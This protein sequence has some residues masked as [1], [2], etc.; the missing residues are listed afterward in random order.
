MDRKRKIRKNDE[1]VGFLGCEFSNFYKCQFTINGVTFNCVEQAFMYC[2]AKLFGDHE[3]A[4]EILKSV[5]PTQCKKLGRKVKGFNDK[6]WANKREVYMEKLLFA[7]FNSNPQ[8]KKMLLDTGDRIIVECAPFDKIWGIGK[9]VDAFFES[10]CK[11]IN[12]NNNKLGNALMKVRE[13]L[14]K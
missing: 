10:G 13:Q 3:I 6:I 12:E 14:N 11:G 9:D 5:N 2:K 1:F 8:L 4:E 7:K